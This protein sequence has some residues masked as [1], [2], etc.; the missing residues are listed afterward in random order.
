MHSPKENAEYYLS[1]GET[2][3]NLPAVKAIILGI[4]AGMFIA[5]ASVTST[6]ASSTIQN[7]AVA[8]LVSGLVFPGG[9]AMVLIA[10]SELFTGNT[11]LVIPLLA[12]RIKVRQMLKNWVCVYIGNYIGSLI[13]ALLVV[14]GGVIS[15]FA[16]QAAVSTI[17]IAVGKVTMTFSAALFKGILC[18]FLVCIAVWMAYM[19]KD[20]TGK[21]VGL[22]FPIM[23]FVTSG[24]EHSVANMYYVTA[25]LLARTNPIYLAAAQTANESLNVGALTVGN[26]LIKNLLPVTIGNILGS[27]VFICLPYWF[28]YLR[29]SG[30]TAAAKGKK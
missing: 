3:A 5:L 10:G 29:N 22:F 23:F 28:C 17:N 12:G 16:N 27:V 6:I 1:V 14:N 9:L 15:A 19:A 8:K 11:L 7:A 25:G 21:I 20:V 30:K 13:I 4:L 18:N 24:Y 26:M 2:K